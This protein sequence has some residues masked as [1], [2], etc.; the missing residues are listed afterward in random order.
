MYKF[1]SA[2]ITLFYSLIDIP[3]LHLLYYTAGSSGYIFYDYATVKGTLNVFRR[4]KKVSTVF[5]RQ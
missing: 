5:R 4:L 3:P 1:F 2:L